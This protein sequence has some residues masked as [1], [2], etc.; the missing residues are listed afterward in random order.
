MG[1]SLDVPF[2]LNV[3]AR[4][5]ES[6]DPGAARRVAKELDSRLRGNERISWRERVRMLVEDA[7][8]RAYAPVFFAAP[9]TP[10]S[11]LRLPSH[12]NTRG[13]SAG[14][15]LIFLAPALRTRGHPLAKGRAP[16]GAPP[17]Y[18]KA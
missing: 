3:S 8:G 5:R 6:G 12:R 4:P 16:S 14:R 15:R 2:G 18:A 7:R 1:W 9:G 13:W 17:S 10:S 11:R